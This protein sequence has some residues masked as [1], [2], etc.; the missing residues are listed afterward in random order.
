[1]AACETCDDGNR[2]DGDGCDRY[3]RTERCF[4]CAGTAP[5]VCAAITACTAGDLCCPVG[6]THATD[7]DCST[8]VPLGPEFQVNSITAYKIRYAGYEGPDVAADA[9]GNFVVVWR[10]YRAGAGYYSY[11]NQRMLSRRFD[12][13]ANPRG[14]DLVVGRFTAAPYTDGR[15]I[16]VASNADGKFV[17]VW[18]ENYHSGGEYGYEA[19]DVIAKRFSSLGTPASGAFVVNAYTP[20]YQE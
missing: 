4:A 18:G 3:C 20:S 17:V 6:C 13:R 16:A 5:S 15:V 1:N 9:A 10:D 2:T 14:S 19:S 11:G 8:A 12:N 7:D